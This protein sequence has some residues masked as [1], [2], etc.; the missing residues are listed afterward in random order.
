[1]L[2]F[3]KT[4]TNSSR[5]TKTEWSW[6]LYDWANSSFGII[7]V[8]AVLPIFLTSIGR[9]AGFSSADIN[10]Y[11]SY[12]NS[13]STLLV[14]FS[15]PILGAL[16]DFAGMKGRLFNFFTGLGIL[17]TAALALVGDQHFWTLLIVFV[18]AN[19]G[20]SAANIFYDS[21]LIDVSSDD[22][23]DKVSSTG[24][25]WGYM[26]GLVPF[27]AFYLMVSMHILKGNGAYYTAF[28]IA[29]VWWLIWTIPF[30]LNVRQQNSLVKPD[31]PV[32]AAY[33][34][35]LHTLKHLMTTDYRQMALFLLAYFFYIDGINTIF[36]VASTFGLAVGISSSDLLM[37]LLVVQLV[38]FPF[39]II[40]GILSKKFGTKKLL[41]TGIII[42]LFISF[43]ALFIH[44][45]TEFWILGV[46]VGTSQGGIQALSRSY[47]GKLVPKEHASEFFGFFNIFGKFSAIIG[48]FLF[49]VV[50]QISGQVQIGAFSMA[51]LFSI[52]LII[53]LCVKEN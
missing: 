29:A 8:T 51:I 6:I 33:S 42:Y 24:Y 12:A 9:K 7:V 41:L 28:I 15:A 10:A 4:A 16:A 43:Y 14:A 35:I 13:I 27:L 52:G 47:F 39:S 11:W 25:G 23:M 53:L 17:A 38:A 46:L 37:V 2:L 18:F 44:S 22:R 19:I 1:M 5:L 48:P 21:Y 34:E 36:T 50:S 49:G 20:Y 30:W 3:K 32:F 26:G 40:Y 31:R 45:V